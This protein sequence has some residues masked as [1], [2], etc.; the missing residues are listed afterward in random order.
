VS[1]PT[2]LLMLTVIGLAQACSGCR[3]SAAATGHAASESLADVA[4]ELKLVFLPSTRLVGVEREHGM[5]DCI[6]VKVEM[7]SEEVSPF[8]RSTPVGEQAFDPGPAPTFGDDHGFWDPHRSTQLRSASVLTSE[9]RGF[10]IGVAEARAF[11]VAV[12]IVDHGT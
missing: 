11:V 9:H 6:R 10:H 4:R 5:D 2:A 8:L 1:R 7:S 3:K 12:Y